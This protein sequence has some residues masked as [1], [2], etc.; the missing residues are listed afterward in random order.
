MEQYDNSAYQKMVRDR[1]QRDFYILAVEQGLALSVEKQLPIDKSGEPIPWYTYPSI[2]YLSKID[3]SNLNIFEYG[4]GHS[5]LYWN[6]RGANVMSVDHDRNWVEKI[7]PLVPENRLLYRSE[8]KQYVYAIKE[9]DSPIDVLVIDGI[10]RNECAYISI[11]LLQ[12][13]SLVILDNSDWFPTVSEFLKSMGFFPI[14]FNGFGPINH[15]CWTTSL[16][17]RDFSFWVTKHA[18]PI[19]IGGIR[20]D[21]SFWK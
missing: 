13:H 14:D 10:H 11:P 9:F 7:M 15:Y 1:V 17:F 18:Q 16:F 21:D 8:K 6:K 20:E 12:Q 4:C 2:E 19:P 5:S 3:F